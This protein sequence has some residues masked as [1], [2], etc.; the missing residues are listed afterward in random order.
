[1]KK[2]VIIIICFISVIVAIAL[3][4]AVPAIKHEILTDKYGDEFMDLILENHSSEALNV[5]VME[6]GDSSATVYVYSTG[7]PRTRSGHLYKYEKQGDE[8]YETEWRTLWS[9]SGS[10]DNVIFPYWWHYAYFLF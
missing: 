1:M 4:H 6:Y 2:T 3:I 7:E 10:A 9:D 8:W 5:K